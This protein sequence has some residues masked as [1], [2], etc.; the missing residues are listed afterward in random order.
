MQ[1]TNISVFGSTMRERR[2]GEVKLGSSAPS[3]PSP[4][5]R[6]HLI[7]NDHISLPIPLPQERRT[8]VI[9]YA[10]QTWRQMRY[11][12][13]PQMARPPQTN[14]SNSPSPSLRIR[15]PRSTSTSL[16]FQLPSLLSS[17]PVHPNRHPILPSS[18]AT[19]TPCQIATTLLSL[20]VRLSTP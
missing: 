2:G 9:R 12:R 14:L 6:P 8:S 13:L 10:T 7:S 1:S 16:S 4:S 20:S 15:I 5:V 11:Q 19:Y 18:A 3:L 17:Q